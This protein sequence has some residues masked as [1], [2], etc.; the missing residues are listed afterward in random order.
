MPHSHVNTASAAQV[1]RAG[2]LVAFPTET[3]Y[4][5][6][7]DATNPQAVARIFAVK[8]RPSFDPLIVHVPDMALAHKVARF[9]DVAEALARAFWPGPLTLV[10]DKQ[11]AIPDIVTS[12]LD[13]VGVRVPDHPLAQELLLLARVPVAAPSA[14]RFGQVSPTTAQHVR[15]QLG[16]E[17]DVI[18]DGGPCRVGVESTIVLVTTEGVQLLRPGGLA[19][20][21]IERVAGPVARGIP[22][23][24]REAMASSPP[25]APGMLKSHYSPG[26]PVQLIAEGEAVEPSESAALL[27]FRTGREGFGACEVLS[28]RGALTEAAANLFG[29]LRRLGASGVSQIYAE[30]LPERGLGLAIMDRLTRAAH[31]NASQA[32]EQDQ[33][34]A[35]QPM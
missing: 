23:H 16:N 3:V 18:L 22:V 10:L 29:A 30:R 25:L 14:N 7:A 34:E 27:A 8:R 32:L 19:V 15:E 9:N 26:P 24:E 21:D 5:L 13:T 20:E 11:Q 28:A 6:G 1:L 31:P 35:K 2:G 4:G 33:F 12:G 17:I